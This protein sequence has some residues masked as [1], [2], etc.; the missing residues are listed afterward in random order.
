MQF[1]DA[2]GEPDLHSYAAHAQKIA[3]SAREGSGPEPSPDMLFS[4]ALDGA[5]ATHAGETKLVA[6]SL[7]AVQERKDEGRFLWPPCAA[8]RRRPPTSSWAPAPP[9]DCRCCCP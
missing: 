2:T 4:T 9:G 7:A 1:A 8:S 6:P 3:R 5:A